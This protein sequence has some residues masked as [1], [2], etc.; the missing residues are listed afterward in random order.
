MRGRST[1]L[2]VAL[3]VLQNPLISQAA[4]PP[5]EAP[6]GFDTP[7]LI[8][9]PGSKST[10]NGI[11]QPPGD[12]FAQV[13]SCPL[14]VKGVGCLV[15]RRA[16]PAPCIQ[17]ACYEREEDLPPDDLVNENEAFIDRLN[18]RVYGGSQS[19][20]PLPIAVKKVSGIVDIG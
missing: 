18:R 3:T 1:L 11:V 19:L 9:R 16:K 4:P 2:V 12:T 5:T 17:H 7:T 10:S 20:L 14:F 8:V 6:A 15:H 13:Y